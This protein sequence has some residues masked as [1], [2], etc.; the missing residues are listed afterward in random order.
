MITDV[1]E[2][3]AKSSE[4]V[5]VLTRFGP[6]TGRRA[7]NGTAVFLEIPFALP[8]ARFE[9]PVALPLDFRYK[10]IEYINE[11]CYAAQPMNNGQA[12]GFSVQDMLGL[13]SPTENPL[14]LNIFIPPSYDLKQES[15]RFPVKVYIHGG[16]LQFGS[17]HGLSA[18]AQYVAAARDEIYVNIGY[19]LSAF[20]FL[21]CDSPRIEGN[22]GFKDQWLALE[23][24]KDNISA[25]GGDPENIQL[26][27]L[28]AGAHSVH[29]ILHHA[30]CLPEGRKAPFRSAAL[31]SNAI[32]MAPKTPAELRPQFSALCSALSIDPS[33]PDALETLKDPVKTPWQAIT[34]AID[35]EKLGAFGTFR[36]CLD[37]D[38]LAVSPEPMSWQHSGGFAAGLRRVGVESIIVGD[39]RDEWYLYALSHPI[40]SPDDIRKNLLRYYPAECTDV[41]LAMYPPL[42]KDAKQEDCFEQFGRILSDMQVHLPVRILY[43]D[44]ISSGFPVIRYDIRW[45]PEQVRQIA[46]GYV[47][48][49]T[50]RVIWCYFEPFLS[51]SQRAVALSWLAT[52]DEELT[53]AEKAA[54]KPLKDVQQVLTLREDM[55]IG[56]EIDRRFDEVMRLLKAL[57]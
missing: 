19:R 27:G 52:I 3:L 54:G 26:T 39:L 55:T 10:D 5:T 32:V 20:G 56:W 47:T 57:T 11:S 30:S 16:F 12:A 50:D 24:I 41:L 34:S 18:Q 2:E 53:K 7:T 43:R 28:S 35:A 45:T 4:R 46:K 15:L 44:L 1:S 38:W 42:A 8:P 48:H 29:Q 36:G 37:G 21:A 49:G 23:W 14:F 13:G 33:S 9:N 25:F 31:Q 6:V 40:E 51:E 17:P 22:F